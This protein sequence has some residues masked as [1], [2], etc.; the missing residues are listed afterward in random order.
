[1][2]AQAA[3]AEVL[4]KG[5]R[6]WHTGPL[7]SPTVYIET[8]VFKFS[9]TQLPR[10]FP[11]QVV[12][13]LGEIKTEMTV[14]DFRYVN[15][16]SRIKNNDVLK[17]EAS[18]LEQ[19]ASLVK[20]GRVNAVTNF[21][22]HIETWNLPKMDSASG[23]FY[24]ARVKPIPAPFK[25]SRII[26]GEYPQG[27]FLER[28]NH[29][30][31]LELQKLTGAYQGEKPRNQNQLMDA[32]QLWCAEHGNC[33]YFLTLD[34]KL[35]KMVEANKSIPVHTRLVRPSDLLKVFD[36]TGTGIK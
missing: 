21:E 20:A 16:N 18:L 23:K 2:P 36:S 15:P 11:R 1:M 24:G 6:N 8:S 17:A 27:E 5:R 14:H 31:F 7:V 22:T 25:Y 26:G 30:R 10:L 4:P 19:I 33:E 13:D 34:F 3:A 29:P 12:I 9:A 28:L 35:I 32:F